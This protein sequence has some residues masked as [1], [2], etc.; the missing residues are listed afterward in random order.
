MVVKIDQERLTS[1]SK[2]HNVKQVISCAALILSCLI[3]VSPEATAS[4]LAGHLLVTTY[5][6]STDDQTFWTVDPATGAKVEHGTAAIDSFNDDMGFSGGKLY[7]AQDQV[8]RV[9]E[10][11]LE[12]G[13]FS[14][15]TSGTDKF[16]NLRDM[17]IDSDGGLWVLGGTTVSRLDPVTGHQDL[18][19]DDMW[20]GPGGIYNP[21]SIATEASGMMLRS[22]VSHIGNGDS[23]ISRLDPATGTETLL[24][25]GMDNPTGLAVADDGS[26][27]VIEQ[28]DYGTDYIGIHRIDPVTGQETV[29]STDPLIGRPFGEL[30]WVP[31]QGLF[32]ISSRSILSID[33]A[34]GEVGTLTTFSDRLT[35]HMAVVPVPE[36]T[37]TG[38]LA[39]G[40]LALMH[41]RHG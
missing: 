6:T 14:V 20:D 1:L 23:G 17:T 24:A 29:I 28:Q 32:K 25:S 41:R 35:P 40:G 38:I 3:S 21:F 30:T 18:Y 34:T 33:V 7:V 27:Y 4:S 12:S 2:G 8:F 15:V 5:D 37:A 16:G 22:F 13:A 9:V 26:I 31:G 11:D 39:L 36:P 10:V 19:Y